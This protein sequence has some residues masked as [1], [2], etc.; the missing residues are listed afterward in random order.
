MK[1]KS[2]SLITGLI[3]LATSSFS[4]AAMVE[5]KKPDSNVEVIEIIGKFTA[6][7]LEKIALQAKLDMF[8]TFNKYNT[9]NEFKVI[10]EP[11]AEI[12][13]HIKRQHC[14]PMY[15]KN[16]YQELTQA[17]FVDH[18]I[19][20]GRNPNQSRVLFAVQKKKQQADDHLIALANKHPDLKLQLERYAKAK[21]AFEL[22][23]HTA[24]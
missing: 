21:T 20:L 16:K 23:K 9:I 4:F 3:L 15:Y 8:E 6:P 10:C 1:T 22:K 14:E 18:K 5:Q 11:R 19:R 13:S 24:N 12:G 7:Q 2:L 17:I